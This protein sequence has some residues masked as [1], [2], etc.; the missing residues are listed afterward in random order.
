MTDLNRSL[1][2]AYLDICQNL[3]AGHLRNKVRYDA[4]SVSGP[5]HIGNQVWLYMPSV[6]SGTAK[7]LASLWH[8]LYTVIDGI[9][10]SNY[11]IQLICVPSK[12]L[13]VHQ[14]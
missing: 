9:N 14:D 11:K 2:T 5:Y 8:G 13:V 12:T 7:K 3:W 1:Q 6:K 4:K 10:S